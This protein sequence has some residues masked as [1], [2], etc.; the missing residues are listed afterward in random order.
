LTN[1]YIGT[2]MNTTLTDRS[3]VWRMFFLV[4]GG[5]EKIWY[6]WSTGIWK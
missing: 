1:K 2:L 3:I 6:G 4:I 5:T